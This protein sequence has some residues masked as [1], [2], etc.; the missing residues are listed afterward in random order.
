MNDVSVGG[1][2]GAGFD[3]IRRRPL[4]VLT[5]GLLQAAIT[6][7]A[8]AL[9]LPAYLSII[10]RIVAKGAGAGAAPDPALLAQMMQM[11]GLSLLLSLASAAATIV[12][13]CAALRAVLFPE[14]SRAAYM[15]LGMAELLLGVA[16]VVG[17]FGFII[18]IL[19]VMIPVVIVIAIFAAAHQP[20]IGALVAVLVGIAA[21]A[22]VV[23]LALRLSLLAPMIVRDGTLALSEAWAMSKGHVGALFVIALCQVLV[24]FLV[25]ALLIAAILLLA[26][27][28]LSLGSGLAGLQ[29]FVQHPTAPSVGQVIPWAALGV[30]LFIPIAGGVVAFMA[31]PWARVLR[32]VTHADVLEPFT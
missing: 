30:V 2:L 22:V 25:E 11:Q 18:A 31:A 5:W 29:S 15:R 19:L 10:S 28:V 7:L 24:V 12:V 14:R 23:Y 9:Y 17:Y 27:G 3:L 16:G 26:V 20:A 1:A 21:F 8:W 32:D 6:G 4:S 13:Y